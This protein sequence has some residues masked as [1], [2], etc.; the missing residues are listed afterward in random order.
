MVAKLSCLRGISKLAAMAI[1]SEVYDLR[2][3]ATAN[4]FMAFLG[5]VPSERSSGQKSEAESPRPETSRV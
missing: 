1:L 5:V 3:F 2:R 4:Q